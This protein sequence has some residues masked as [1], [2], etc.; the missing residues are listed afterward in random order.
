MKIT[1]K[2]QTFVDEY[3]IDLNGTQAAIR[4]GYSKRTASEQ[5]SRLLANVKVQAVIQE[6]MKEREKRTGITADRVLKQL[7]KIAFSDMKDFM[8]W[9]TVRQV[10]EYQEVWV[11]DE[12]DE[13]TGKPGKVLKN[14]PVVSQFTRINMKTS[15][16]V[17]GTI[18]QEVK[19]ENRGGSISHSIKLNDRMKALELLGKHLGMFKENVNI[20]GNLVTIVDDIEDAEEEGEE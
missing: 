9:E 20:T 1:K 5:A 3:L 15:D 4:A 2:Q 14:L 19:E 8:S 12:V 10:T 18:I 6:K 11:D 7:E 16:E 13:E 17:D